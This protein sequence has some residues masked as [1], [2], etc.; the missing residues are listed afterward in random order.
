MLLDRTQLSVLLFLS[1]MILPAKLFGQNASLV[2]PSD[3]VVLSDTNVSFMWNYDPAAV[4]YEFQLSLDAGF[5]LMADSNSFIY[6]TTH[7]YSVPHAGQTYY[8]RVRYFNGITYSGWSPVRT[9]TFFDP[10]EISGLKLWLRSDTGI[11]LNSG[12]VS[13]WN[14]LSGFGNHAGQTDT[15]AK[16]ALISNAI[17]NLPALRFI[18]DY[19]TTSSIDVGEHAE[20]MLIRQNGAPPVSYQPIIANLNPPFYQL[21]VPG[22]NTF[23]TFHGSMGFD[24][25]IS[26]GNNYQFFS[27]IISST[28][29]NF[30]KNG[31]AGTPGADS[32][33]STNQPLIIGN[34]GTNYLNGDIT[35]IIIYDHALPDSERTRVENYL[36]DRYARPV[37]L[38]PDIT[39]CAFPVTLLA[40]Q[41]YYTNYLWSDASTADSLVVSAAGNYFVTVT[42]IFGVTSSDTVSVFLDN[43]N[44]SVNLPGDTNICYGTSLILTAGPPHLPYLWSTGSAS[45][46]IS[47]DT[48]GSY[49]VSVTDCNGNVS[50]DTINVT[51]VPLPVFSLGNDTLICFN[52]PLLLDPQPGN[53]VS[54]LW[55]DN[56]TDST[57]TVNCTGTY[58]LRVQDTIGCLY[59]DT[60][61]IRVDS[62]LATVSLGPDDSLCAGNDIA[63]VSGAPQ[64]QT[65]LWSDN[66]TGA[67][68]TIQ[69]TGTYWVMVTDSNSCIARDTITITI[70][71]VAPSVNFSAPAICEGNTSFFTDLT[72]ASDTTV[73]WSWNFGEPSSGVNN[74]SSLQNP[75]HLYADIGTYMVT[76][77]DTTNSGWYNDTIIAVRV[78]PNPVPSFTHPPFLCTGA[79]VLFTNT[80]DTVGYSVTSWLLYFVDPGSGWNNSSSLKN[81]SH[82]FNTSGNFSV[83]LTVTLNNGCSVTDTIVVSVGLTVVPTFSFFN[84][85]IGDITNFFTSA[86]GVSLIWNF[87]DNTSSTQQSPQHQYA[88]VQMYPCTLIAITMAGCTSSVTLPVVIH[89][90]PVAYFKNNSAC[91]NVPYHLLDSSYI[92]QGTITQWLWKLPDFSTSVLQNPYYTFN[93]TIQYNITLVV[94]SNYGC[95]DTATRSVKVHPL[96]TA[97]FT[98]DVAYGDVPLDVDFTNLSSGAPSYQLDF[99]DTSRTST[100][101]SASYTYTEHGTYPVTLIA[102]TLYY[103]SDTTVK[104]IYV[105]EPVL[106]LAVTSVNK[107]SGT[108]SISL[109]AGIANL[110][111]IAVS[112][113]KISAWLENSLP[114]FEYWNGN[115]P[116]Q[117]TLQPPYSFAAH[118]VIPQINL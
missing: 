81:P 82:I 34:Y 54:Y 22:S 2:Y 74:F 21:Y 19:L 4:R 16:P 110:G 102:N 106:D 114:V 44:F 60:V 3:N 103:C 104:Y 87:G 9:F 80:T 32:F 23:N 36:N 45:N 25:G 76:L 67:T 63:L 39:V 14:D 96:P 112:S 83:T 37:N 13:Q 113:F 43:S 50:S 72:P 94:T 70:S 49:Y 31:V 91:L 97:S 26:F 8:W 61:F 68:L 40:Q 90:V 56:S 55:S 29:V 5:T 77:I 117:S 42:N 84:T 95:K 69:N 38:G 10:S 53:N 18:N 101:I 12:N 35:E 28:N 66:S 46:Y 88:F 64:V 116:P 7:A 59:S 48:S 1:C 51:V 11:T 73:A 100:V 118:F 93:D 33:T 86:S 75:S 65:Y 41:G 92:S 20:F 98:S 52:Q 89:D 109:S 62:A 105:V 27:R 47:V 30:Y 99:W 58:Y 71:G 15:S 108:N 115:F 24:H 79:P 111:N 6:I 107:T 85:C 17:N 78:Y 57:L